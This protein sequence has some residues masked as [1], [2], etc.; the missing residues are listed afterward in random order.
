M[1][2]SRAVA[3]AATPYEDVDGVRVRRG[4]KHGYKHV[5]GGQ[6]R[7]KNLFQAHTPLKNQKTRTARSDLQTSPF[8]VPVP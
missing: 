2:R 8:R 6:G 1:A 5:R 3:R 7:A 4:G